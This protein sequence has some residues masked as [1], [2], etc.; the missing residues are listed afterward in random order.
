MNSST[1]VSVQIISK[2]AK[3]SCV[4]SRRSAIGIPVN[5]PISRKRSLRVGCE[6]VTRAMHGQKV[7]WVGRVGFKLLPKTKDMVID[8]ARGRII[9]VTPDFVQ[10]FFP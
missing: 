6:L 9:G 1:P 5:R 2:V 4:R 3:R 10:Y 7:A 8:R